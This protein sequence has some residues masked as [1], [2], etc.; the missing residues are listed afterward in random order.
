MTTKCF[1]CG[2]TKE[3][4]VHPENWG[5]HQKKVM[6]E[7]EEARNMMNR[8]A[9]AYEPIPEDKRCQECEGTGTFE[10]APGDGFDC[11]ECDAK[12]VKYE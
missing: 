8:L 10:P 12:G 4:L 5:E 3:D 9:H 11:Q 2:N 1:K 6:A 7:D